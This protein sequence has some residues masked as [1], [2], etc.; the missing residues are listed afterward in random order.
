MTLI[1]TA[2]YKNGIC[3][4]ADRRYKIKDSGSVRFEDNHNKIYKFKEVPF[5]ILNHGIN[6]IKN[7][8]WRVY[9]SEYEESNKWVG[10]DQFQITNDFK[11]FVEKDVTGELNIQG[12]GSATGFLLLGKT[13]FDSKFRVNELFWIAKSDGVEFKILRH[14]GFIRTGDARILLDV[15]IEHNPEFNTE[16]YWKSL[17]LTK[18][19]EELIKLFNIAV[20]EKKRLNGNDFSDQFDI[21]SIFE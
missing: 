19:Q 20:Q 4:C 5:I 21:G 8:D 12:I 11:N 15:F 2:F 16:R 1:L 18:V 13:S 7:K 14:K 3:I 17:D 10:K 6:K 9:C